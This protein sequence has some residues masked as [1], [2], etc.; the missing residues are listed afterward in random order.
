MSRHAVGVALSLRLHAAETAIDAALAETARLAVLLPAARA[1]ARLSATVGGKAFD[2]TAAAIGALATARSHLIDTHTTLSA[3][4]R[5]LG[6]D[7]LAVGPLDK[8]EDDIRPGGGV[9]PVATA[10]G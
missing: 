2:G 9:A 3:L 8:P 5:R 6:L 1:R 7:D 4:A 10:K